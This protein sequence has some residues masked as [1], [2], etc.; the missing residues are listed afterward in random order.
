LREAILGAATKEFAKRGFEGASLNRI[1]A[2]AKLSKGSFYYYFDDKADLAATALAEVTR[3]V[4]PSVELDGVVDAPTFWA[5]MERFQRRTLEPLAHDPS[6]LEL[7][8][9]LG[10]AYVDHPELAAKVLPLLQDLYELAFSFWVRGQE[11]GAVRKDLP[12]E[13][14]V[15]VLTGVKEALLRARLPRDRTVTLHELTELATLQ[16]DLFRRLTAP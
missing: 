6:Q 4:T 2:S 12:V 14:L 3:G 13:Q 15:A 11:V 16:L 5:A 10:A 8:S 1:I 7:V 9:K